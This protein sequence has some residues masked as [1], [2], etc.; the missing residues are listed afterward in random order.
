V[1]GALT[2]QIS[3]GPPVRRRTGGGCDDRRD[4]VG[5][6]VDEEQAA[7]ARASQDV[8]WLHSEIQVRVRIQNMI[9]ASHTNGKPGSFV[10]RRTFSIINE[11]RSLNGLSSTSASTA[12]LAGGAQQRHDSAHRVTEKPDPRVSRFAC[13]RT[14][15]PLQFETSLI[16]N[17]IGARSLPAWPAIRIEDDVKPLRH[18]RGGESRAS[19]GAGPYVRLRR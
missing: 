19:P 8:F 18:H 12:G 7:A 13:A 6:P 4:V 5:A 14:G 16:P 17:V 3:R 10:D 15:A 1:W 2:I 9:P 11:R